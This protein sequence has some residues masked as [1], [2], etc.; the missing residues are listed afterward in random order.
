MVSHGAQ[1][2][3]V[4]GADRLLEPPDV[5]VGGVHQ[6]DRLLRAVGAVRIDVQIDVGP[7]DVASLPDPGRI[8]ASRVQAPSPILI[9]TEGSAD[10]QSSR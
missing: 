9:L 5:A 7:D 10:R 1:S 6:S 3:E 2:L 8:R 4:V